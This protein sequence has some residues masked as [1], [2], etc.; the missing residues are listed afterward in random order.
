M[1][2]PNKVLKYLPIVDGPSLRD[3]EL[4]LT[5]PVPL[6]QSR[7]IKLTVLVRGNKVQLDAWL[8]MMAFHPANGVSTLD[9]QATITWHLGFTINDQFDVFGDFFSSDEAYEDFSSR[10]DVPVYALYRTYRRKGR[11]A[12]KKLWSW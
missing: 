12:L 7:D 9:F 1:A 11:I 5:D 3:L 8:F 6:G 4:A 10:S 2:K